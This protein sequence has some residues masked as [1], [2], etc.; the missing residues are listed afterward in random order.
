MEFVEAIA[1]SVINMLGSKYRKTVTGN[2]LASNMI[3]KLELRVGQQRVY[4]DVTMT[5]DVVIVNT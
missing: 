5:I 4:Y 3:R 2:T 1:P